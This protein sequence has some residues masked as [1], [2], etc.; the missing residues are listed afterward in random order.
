MKSRQIILPAIAV[1]LSAGCS[2][3]AVQHDA[4]IV[5]LTN[6]EP[7]GCEYLGDITGSEGGFWTGSFTSSRNLDEGARNDLKNRAHA[8]G[9]NV[10]ALLTQRSAQS[11]AT[12]HG[13]GGSS[14]T[15]VVLTGNV[16]RCPHRRQTGKE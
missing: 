13:S 12:S 9:G 16:Y 8:M 6:G 5:R 1:L 2:A 7:T 10:V 3:T 4:A 14:D 11:G 15:S